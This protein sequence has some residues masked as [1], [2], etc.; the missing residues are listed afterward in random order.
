MRSSRLV[1]AHLA[2]RSPTSAGVLISIF[3]VLGA[4]R[5]LGCVL[6]LDGRLRRRFP[7]GLLAPDHL[8]VSGVLC[9][10]IAS[11]AIANGIPSAAIAASSKAC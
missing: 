4:H 2:K 11:K 10:P 5:R 1:I 7:S 6:G 3:S 8:V 9:G